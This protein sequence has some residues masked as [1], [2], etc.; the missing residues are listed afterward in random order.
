MND[1]DEFLLEYITE[2]REHLA[3]AE[4][5][6]LSLSESNI[7]HDA[8]DS[9]FRSLHTVKGGAGFL[10][11]TRIQGVAHVTEQLL[12][13]LNTGAITCK[14]EHIDIL[15]EAVSQLS[16]LL[17]DENIVQGEEIT[18]QDQAII[19]RLSEQLGIKKSSSA[20]REPVNIVEGFVF[21]DDSQAQ[22]LELCQM[23]HSNIPDVIRGLENIRSIKGLPDSIV[24][25]INGI[26]TSCDSIM[27]ADEETQ[28]SVFEDIRADA[29][30]IVDLYNICAQDADDEG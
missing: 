10:D 25:I 17:Q 21:P 14:T 3:S 9:C 24:V 28:K 7:D 30:G 18:E 20:Q 12:E 2:A 15:L 11:L 23:E 1:N 13:E 8:M 5:Q 27:F 16:L 26:Q 19:D 29:Q 6:L 4:E 22:L